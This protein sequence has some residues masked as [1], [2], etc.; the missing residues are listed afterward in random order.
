M[1]KVWEVT[2]DEIER[3]SRR[4]EAS[5][6]LPNLVRRLLFATVSPVLIQSAPRDLGWDLLVE[7]P[8]GGEFCP[9]GFSSWETKVGL[10]AYELERHFEARLRSIPASAARTTA[11]FVTAERFPRKKTWQAERQKAG[12]VRVFDADDIAAWLLKA[13]AVACSVSTQLGHP[14]NAIGDL[15]S[16]LAQWARRTRPPLPAELLLLGRD[17][18]RV[19]G[20]VRDWARSGARRPLFVQGETTDEARAFAAAALLADER[21]RE[22]FRARTL[23][24]STREAL[25]GA[26][27]L[28]VDVPL[29]FLHA[30]DDLQAADVQKESPLLLADTPSMPTG[31]DIVS[32]PLLDKNLLEEKLKRAGVRDPGRLAARSRGSVR[33]LQ[34]LLGYTEPP[35]W[36]APFDLHALSA[37]LL[38]EAWDP[39]N[40]ADRSV[41]RALGVDPDAVEA[42]CEVVTRAGEP[43]FERATSRWGQTA[44]ALKAPDAAWI[45]LGAL[46][47]EGL[48]KRFQ[49]VAIE[50]LGKD[51][52]R[53][54]LPQEQWFAAS[55]FGKTLPESSM[56]RRGITRALARLAR[57]PEEQVIA[58]VDNA[59]GACLGISWR[60]WASTADVLPILAEAS[61]GNFLERL[62]ES[63]RHGQ[64]GAQQLL[65]L[66]RLDTL[67]LASYSSLLE[68]LERI[69][70]IPEHLSR[71]ALCLAR[72]AEE[73]LRLGEHPRQ[74]SALPKQSLFKLLHF[75]NPQTAAPREKRVEVMHE[76]A[77]RAPGVAFDVALMSI[78]YMGAGI[79]LPPR[80]PEFLPLDPSFDAER[81]K[82]ANEDA[83]VVF[84][85]HVDT[86]LAL[87]G[88]DGERWARLIKTSERLERASPAHAARILDLL[89]S[90]RASMTDD[91]M[92]RVRDALRGRL[93]WLDP[94]SEDRERRERFEQLYNDFEPVD[95]VARH[96]WLFRPPVNLPN[97]H[98][99]LAP[100]KWQDEVNRL[101]GNAIEEIGRSSIPWESL[102]RLG[103]ALSASKYSAPVF[104][105]W[106]AHASFADQLEARVID[107]PAEGELKP[108][109]PAFIASRAYRIGSCDEPWLESALKKL[110]AQG[111]IDE[112]R[113]ALYRIPASTTL[114]DLIERMGE[115]LRAAYWRG[116]DS[117]WLEHEPSAWERGIRNLIAAGNLAAAVS[118]A[119]TGKEHVST[120]TKLDALEAL[121]DNGV[122]LERFAGDE[123]AHYKIEKILEALD[124]DPSLDETRM[125][126]VE[127][128]CML[129]F[130]DQ[131]RPTRRVSKLMASNPGEMLALLRAMYSGEGEPKA[132]LTTQEQADV[133][134]R[135][136]S[137]FHFLEQWN[138][139]PGEGL[140]SDEREAQLYNW[141]LAVLRGADK[142]GRGDRAVVHVAEVLARAPEADDMNWPCLAARRLLE[143]K[144]FADLDD[145][146][147]RAKF[148]LYGSKGLGIGEMRDLTLALKVSADVMRGQYPRTASMLDDLLWYYE[149]RLPDE[150]TKPVEPATFERG[151][152]KLDRVEI[153]N[154]RALQDLQ[155][156]L[157]APRDAE[158]GQWTVLL[159]EN[160]SGKTTILRALAMA[161]M[162]SHIAN[163]VLGFAPSPYPRSPEEPATVNVTRGEQ[164]FTVAIYDKQEAKATPNGG[165]LRPFVCGYGVMRG[166]ALSKDTPAQIDTPI[167]YVATLFNSSASLYPTMPWLQSMKLREAGG[168]NIYKTT[169]KKVLCN[170]QAPLLPGVKD[171]DLTPNADFEAIAPSLGGTIP[172]AGLSDGYLSTLGWVVDL[173]ARWI[174]WAEAQ[175]LEIDDDFP[176][177]MEG[178][179]L[180]DE[181][182]Q[183]LH[184]QWQRSIIG[185]LKKIFPRLSFV[186]TTHNPLTLLGAEEGEIHVLR[187]AEEEQKIEAVQFDLP[188]G[189]RPDQVLTGE[190]FGL[191][192]VFHDETRGLLEE[193]RDMLDRRVP[194]DDPRRLEVEEELREQIGTYADTSLDRM[195]LEVAAVLM[196]ERRAKRQK[197]TAKD[198]RELRDELKQRL[199]QQLANEENAWR[200]QG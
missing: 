187:W 139:F 115:P 45:D 198:R 85:A 192:S 33:A 80:K 160:G 3:W 46:I 98:K 169:I 31:R 37:T 146:L 24:T 53:Y 44:W 116:V 50:V 11:I 104:G 12:S 29:F 186:V 10:R 170:E 174:A 152:T 22:M 21:E 153:R 108:F 171:I 158:R 86:V 35:R 100:N 63:L 6:E 57:R 178:L 151:I 93:Y 112:A 77:R 30:A 52:P 1:R 47:P 149:R 142:E 75:A 58:L 79:F 102:A 41:F 70:W 55:M 7:S 51:D 128:H 16:F 95:L 49:K 39:R 14:V 99:E 90:L 13:P 78:E 87:A 27:R 163:G 9:P 65:T 197:L 82:H 114:W 83:R 76:L 68:A 165:A 200:R 150:N 34:T 182:D 8:R 177:R 74:T 136:E 179:V 167:S 126:R 140:A 191:L 2:V 185:T 125:A 97:Y 59:V 199:E 60:R 23:V 18:E 176:S 109:V 71:V 15:D 132:E 117:L 121:L 124:T 67:N 111:R 137:A 107:E 106:L 89:S 144:E 172:L 4:I 26:L 32:L 28:R 88:V 72:L 103:L 159:G 43:V 188:K 166:S 54:E 183:H 127:L 62:E 129:A 184:P 48:L 154:M 64:E 156:D 120:V 161:L 143:S 40:E 20:I 69:G 122:E 81:E 148:N 94:S 134:Q 42:L 84:D 36:A 138:G 61:P 162:G 196:R 123:I 25:L 92:A 113:D 119:E 155:L 17:R 168:V 38:V 194:P 130:G 147:R 135:A 105:H 141:S 175:N 195:A 133:K 66:E 91:S 164:R 56:L 131:G 96:A 101:Q 193:H 19:A 118:A 180:V 73:D 110:L 173:V 189:I 5:S 190:W 145:A 157:K 181:I